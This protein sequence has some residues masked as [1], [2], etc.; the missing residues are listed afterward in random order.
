VRQS[1]IVIGLAGLLSVS[2]HHGGQSPA[3][4]PQILHIC[5]AREPQRVLAAKEHIAASPVFNQQLSITELS[6]EESSPQFA[7]FR[8][9]SQ[10]IQ[11]GILRPEKWPEQSKIKVAFL[12][13]DPA[14][15]SRIEQ[16]ALKWNKYTNVTFQFIDDP[17]QAVI[18]IGVGGNGRS[19]SLIGNDALGVTDKTKETMHFGW[20]TTYSSQADYDSVVLHEFGHALGFVHE[21]QLPNSP[22]I[23]NKQYVYQ[24]CQTQWGWSQA[25]VDQNI[26]QQYTPQQLALTRMDP[27]SIMM[28]SFPAEWTSNSPPISTP[29]N[30]QLSDGDTQLAAQIY[31]SGGAGHP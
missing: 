15:Q 26:F 31:P 30:Y 6:A 5:S 22:I 10:S 29:W 4:P 9:L 27:T 24:Y 3:T 20:L 17:S 1:I 23:W 21:H 7:D 8:R 2:T 19:E 18:R 25:D 12:N 13:G 16:S 14:V 28:Y 11:Q